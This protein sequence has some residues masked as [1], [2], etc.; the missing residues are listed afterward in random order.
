MQVSVSVLRAGFKDFL[1]RARA[2]EEVIV[3]DRGIPVARL[4]PINV[5]SVIE[6]LVARGVIA[7]PARPDRPAATG[8]RRIR[9]RGP[10]ADLV[11]PER[12]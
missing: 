2:G 9:A 12:R 3:T 5:Q 4:V 1:G 8:R 7:P 6:R 10:V 11:S